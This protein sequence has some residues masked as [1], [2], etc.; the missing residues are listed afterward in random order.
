MSQKLLV[1]NFKW[2][3]DT[4]QFNEDLKKTI[5]KIVGKT[6]ELKRKG[7][8]WKMISKMIFLSWCTMQFLEKT[9]SGKCELYVI[10][11]KKILC[12]YSLQFFMFK[13]TVAILIF[14]SK[15]LAFFITMPLFTF[16]SMN[17]CR[18]IIDRNWWR[19][20]YKSCNINKL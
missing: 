15:G 10:Y 19:D 4:S 18:K 6:K 16:N 5:M 13:K 11:H 2:I 12:M 1:N 7:K 20:C 8:K 9:L 14:N 3:K 17:F